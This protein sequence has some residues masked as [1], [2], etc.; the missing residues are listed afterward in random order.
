M[1]AAQF[2]AVSSNVCGENEK[3]MKNMPGQLAYGHI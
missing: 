1:A 3:T 2:E